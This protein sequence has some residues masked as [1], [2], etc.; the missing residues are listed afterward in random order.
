MTSKLKEA[1]ESAGYT[2][3]QVADILKIR[4]Q[5]VI[6]LEEENFHEMPGK[7]YVDGY[8]KIY[9]EFLGLELGDDNDHPVMRPRE[10][11]TVGATKKKLVVLVSLVMLIVVVGLYSFLKRNEVEYSANDL[12]DN[13]VYENR[14]NEK[15]SS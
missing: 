13:V 10:P 14:S 6:D 12:M 3:E 15:R 9:Y 1:R 2:V 5:Y 4:K 8:T 7:I 11:G